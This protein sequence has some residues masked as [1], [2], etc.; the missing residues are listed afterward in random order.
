MESLSLWDWAWILVGTAVAGFLLLVLPQLLPRR[1]AAPVRSPGAPAPT[2][3]VVPVNQGASSVAAIPPAL[4][5]RAW[6]DRAN[7]QPDRTPHLAATGPSGSGKTTLILA[8]LQDRPGRFVIVTPKSRRADPWGGLPVVRLRPEDMS[9]S[10]I[11]EA[12]EAVYTEMLRRNAE[13]ADVDDD[14]LTLVVDEYSTVIGKLPALKE[15]VLDMITLGRSARIRV[16]ILATETNVKAW[17]WEGRGEARANVLFIECEEDTYRAWLF[18][19]GKEREEIDTRQ[20]PQ[21]AARPLS[22]TRLWAAA[23]AP[24]LSDRS[25]DDRAIAA[26]FGLADQTGL[27]GLPHSTAETGQTDADVQTGMEAGV[28]DAE[29]IRALAAAGWS[30]NKICSKMRGAKDKKLRLIDAALAEALTVPE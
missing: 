29:T 15:K 30:K 16:I 11:G 14:W 20:L 6:F 4:P 21:I 22:E 23:P 3:A 19:W 26:L 8:L 24:V 7:Q 12:V 25:A 9:F 5:L 1:R 28:L 17:G 27:S 18:R 13:D 2:R 10:V